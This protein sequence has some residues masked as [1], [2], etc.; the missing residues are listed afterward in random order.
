MWPETRQTTGVAPSVMVIPLAITA[1]LVTL[2]LLWPRVRGGPPAG[3]LVVEVDVTMLA[4]AGLL[5][6]FLVAVRCLPW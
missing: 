3:Q 4:P 5:W 1:D 2:V 6:G